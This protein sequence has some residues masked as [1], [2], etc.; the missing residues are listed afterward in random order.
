MQGA[1]SMPLKIGNHHINHIL[2]VLGGK[3]NESKSKKN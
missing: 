1:V 2:A 3:D